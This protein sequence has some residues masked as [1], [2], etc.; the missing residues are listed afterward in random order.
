MLVQ[1][2]IL[3]AFLIALSA[4]F[5]GV[6]AA[7]ISLSSVSVRKML[8]KKLFGSETVKELKE[9]TPKLITTLL[10]GNN[11]VNI[12]A[13]ALAT[14]ISIRAFGSYGV[15]IATGAMTL[16]ILLFGEISP[17]TIAMRNN[18]AV[19]RYSAKI[20]MAVQ[21]LLYPFVAVFDYLGNFISK[22]FSKKQ[23][24][25]AVTEEEIKSYIKMGEE[26]G[27]IEKEE[28]EMI[29]NI[30]KLNDIEA[31]EVMTPRINIFAF[32]END[33]LKDKISDIIKSGFSRIPVYRKSLDKISGIVYAKD[34]LRFQHEN[35]SKV[36]L[37]QVAKQPL[38]VPETKKVN[39]L[40]SEFRIKAKH[41]AVVVD[42]YGLASGIIT[43]EDILEEIVG[44]IYDESD[45]IK[46][47]II[48]INK[49][50]AKVK[51][52]TSLEDIRKS[53]NIKIKHNGSFDTLSGFIMAKLGKIPKEGEKI[54]LK[55]CDIFIEKVKD[56]RIAV[57]RIV[58]R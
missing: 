31:K 49:K 55:K 57:C 51:G 9:N 27:S 45:S 12:G 53:L 20:I 33:I 38:V 22:R 10:I 34:I 30:F 56:N 28:K 23:P 6:E 11:L 46:R 44:E 2:L 3:L 41:I 54:S 5:S 32:D 35:K 7:F 58:K 19:C 50:T 42:E 52:E 13:S 40:L 17:K 8:D 25:P 37:K 4:F 18:E 29:H 24:E 1:E 16:L 43:I 48:N 47:N 39:E 26:I 14:S 36:K 21:Y 15:G